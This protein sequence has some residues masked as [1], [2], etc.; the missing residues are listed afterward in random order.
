MTSSPPVKLDLRAWVK[1]G[2][3]V[4]VSQGLGEPY[5]L[6][7]ELVS[8]RHALGPIDV[9]LGPGFDSAF[10]ASCADTLRLQSWCATGSN[11]QLAAAGVLDMVPDHYIEL[12]P[13]FESG[14]MRCDVA[15]LSASGPDAQG[16]LFLGLNVDYTLAAARRARVV[17]LEVNEDWPCVPGAELPADIQPS[18]VVRTRRPPT[19]MGGESAPANEADQAIARY[20][21]GL[22]DD[23]AT[24]SLGVGNLP[25]RV[26]QALMNHRDLGIHSP[27]LV[28]RV[29]DLIEAGV[30]TN[31]RKG[32]D[33][34]VTV[35]GLLMGGTR[36]LDF[37]RQ[38]P[39]L[40]L[41]PPSYTHALCT[42]AA[43]PQF[44]AL[45]GAL[46]VDL[47]GQINAETAQGRYVGAVGGQLSLLRGARASKGGQAITLLPSTARGGTVSRIVPHLADAVVTTP[48]CD[49][50]KV[51]TEFGVADLRGKG[52]MA[53]VEAMVRIAHPDF[54]DALAQEGE[55]IARLAR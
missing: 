52:L 7:Q 29:V 54:R 42:L 35:A 21:A 5:G 34:G 50:D 9:F 41:A 43:Q 1:P 24:L 30:V 31:A 15:L 3:A 18:L 27:I 19:P 13:L 32:L 10:D 14:A 37:V 49:V 8:Q 12:G 28:D 11:A 20:A 40:R 4:V 38:R 46:E 36:L 53:R 44:V 39:P 48:R 33:R 2:D 45:T 16:R 55:R 47:T 22:I 51:V 17:I 6:T 23:G 26:L 25:D